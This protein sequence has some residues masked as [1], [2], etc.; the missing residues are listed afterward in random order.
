MTRMERVR[1]PLA[2]LGIAVREAEALGGPA[3]ELV[4]AQVPY[5]PGDTWNA[6]AGKPQLRR[7]VRPRC[8]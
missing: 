7:C 4:V 1:E 6:L 5:H 3:F 8:C 2:R